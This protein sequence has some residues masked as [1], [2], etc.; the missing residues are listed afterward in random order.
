MVVSVP[1]GKGGKGPPLLKESKAVW[2]GSVDENG[3]GRTPKK[4]I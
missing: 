1:V 4:D 3:S 2:S